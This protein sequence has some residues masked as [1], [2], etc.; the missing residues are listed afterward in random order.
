MFWRN[1]WPAFGWA[2]VILILCGFPGDRLPELTFLEWLRPDKIVH[3]VIFGIQ[4][5]LLM[6]GFERQT[7]S[8]FLNRH[9]VLISILFTITYGCIVELMQTYLFIHRSGDVRDAI[10][11]SIGALIGWWIYRKNYNILNKNKK[12]MI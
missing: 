4:S 10:A 7:N 12:R 3:L 5:Y 9:A 11:N 8:V 6:R 1:T 2:V